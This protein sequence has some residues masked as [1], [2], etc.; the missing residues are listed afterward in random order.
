MITN[1]LN[2]AREI[3]GKYPRAVSFLS[4]VL[5][6]VIVVGTVQFYQ[7]RNL[8]KETSPEL[9]LPALNGATYGTGEPRA[10]RTLVYFFAPWCTVC[11]VNFDNLE[12]LKS[13]RSDEKEFRL[14]AVALSYDDV[15]EIHEF[16]EGR[17]T[18]FPVLT[19]TAQTAREWRISA[20]P[21]FYVL[22]E[23]RQ[24]VSSGVG[25]TT[26]LGLWWRTW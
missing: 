26:T 14:L 6:I 1:L 23:N 3:K 16:L 9:N 21:T 12:R 15:S 24:V 20:F 11:K 2:K 4:Q 18:S 17:K 25:Y 8:V 22:D 19:G 13:W 7:T 5:F 10:R